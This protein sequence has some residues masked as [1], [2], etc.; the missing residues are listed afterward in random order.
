MDKEDVVHTHTMESY[1]VI[2]RNKVLPFA[3]V[4]LDLEGVMLNEISQ[5]QS[6]TYY[7][8]SL[9]WGILKNTQTSEYNKKATVS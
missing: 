7:M 5:T 1:S 9:T 4:W 3:A 6:D 2:K 8:L